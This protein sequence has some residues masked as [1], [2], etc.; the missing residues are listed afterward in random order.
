MIVDRIHALIRA[1]ADFSQI[2]EKVVDRVNESLS[3]A[4][5]PIHW[6]KAA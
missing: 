5:L 4:H 3:A 6:R 1:G 2:D